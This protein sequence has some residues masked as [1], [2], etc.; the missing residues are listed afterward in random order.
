M[1]KKLKALLLALI[2]TLSNFNMIAYAAS[3]NNETNQNK[4]RS[5]TRLL[6]DNERRIYVLDLKVKSQEELEKYTKKNP[7]V[8]HYKQFVK[9]VKPKEENK[10]T[11]AFDNAKNVYD[12]YKNKLGVDNENQAIFILPNYNENHAFA[13]HGPNYAFIALGY[14]VLGGSFSD[15]V[16]T[17]GHEYTHAVLNSEYGFSD[18]SATSTKYS[19]AEGICDFVGSIIEGDNWYLKDTYGNTIRNIKNPKSVK[20]NKYTDVNGNQLKTYPD[21]YSNRAPASNED[22]YINSTIVSHLLYTIQSKIKGTRPKVHIKVA[23]LALRAI[24][25]T[26]SKNSIEDFAQNLYVSAY[27]DEKS[28]VKEALKEVGLSSSINLSSKSISLNVGKSKKLTA[29]V[30]PKNGEAS[31][32]VKWSSSNTK[33]ATVSNGTVKA[34]STGKTTITASIKVGETTIKSSCTVTVSPVQRKISFTMKVPSNY[35]GKYY[36]EIIDSSNNKVLGKTKATTGNTKFT[37]TYTINSTSNSYKRKLRVVTTKNKYMSNNFNINVNT[38]SKD[39][40]GSFKDRKVT[41]T[42]K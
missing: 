23:K 33:V 6:M 27:S 40:F 15:S 21:H 1:T 24:K 17:M 13:L 39:V 26:S 34:I 38:I 5:S 19:I 22:G 4:E 3:T 37:S 20:R 29:S 42:Q 7:K 10:Y 35:T 9:K 31:K 12:Y 30:Y 14:T 16:D 32:C 8:E 36:V 41:V 28:V 18:Q 2:I 25:K 11:K